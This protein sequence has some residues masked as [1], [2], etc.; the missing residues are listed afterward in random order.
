MDQIPLPKSYKFIKEDPTESVFVIEPCYPGYGVTMGNALRRVLLSSLPGAAVTSIKIKGV[1]HEFSTIPNVKEDVVDIILNIKKLAVRS[2]SAE[3]IK[4]TLKAKGDK[5]VTAADIQKQ[6][7][8]EIA[9]PDLHIATLDGKNAELEIE[10]V[11]KQGRG[12]VPVET[13]EEEK[14]EI[15]M[16][17][18]DSIYTPVKNVNFSVTSVRVGKITNY[19]KLTMTITTNG[20]ITGREALDQSAEILMSH[21]QLLKGDSMNNDQKEEVIEKKVAKESSD[22][23]EMVEDSSPESTEAAE[24]LLGLNLSRRSYNALQKSGITTVNQLKELTSEQL[25]KIQGLGEKSIK[26]ISDTIQTLNK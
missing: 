18:I 17:A 24:A 15:G 26:E 6:Q 23:V 12:Y 14:L 21:F 9:N 2:H 19:E 1:D 20:T 3:P 7:D 4:I 25:E 11:V 13:R 8:I 10:M 16:I 5:E 22:S